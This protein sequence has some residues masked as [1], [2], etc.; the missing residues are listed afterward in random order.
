MAL[1]RISWPPPPPPLPPCLCERGV[2]PFGDELG[3]LSWVKV[4][5]ACPRHWPRCSYWLRIGI[6][7]REG[8]LWL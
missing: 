4:V 2:Y 8:K 6:M 1:T 3:R 7:I 5:S